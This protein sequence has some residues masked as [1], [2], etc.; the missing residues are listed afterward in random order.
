MTVS[1]KVRMPAFLATPHSHMRREFIYPHRSVRS[2]R[3]TVAKL[4]SAV[5]TAA[6]LC[7]SIA[8]Y[9]AE[10][11]TWHDRLCVT[12]LEWTG[13]PV[14]GEQTIELFEGLSTAVV[15]AVPVAR[16]ESNPLRFVL[17]AVAGLLALWAIQHRIALSRG[18]VLFLAALLLITACVVAIH[19]SSQFGAVEFGQIWL[20]GEVLVWLLLPVFSAAMFT[21]VQPIWLIGVTLT[22]LVQVFGIFWSAVRMAFCLAVMHYS[23]IL[24]VPILWFAL[25][26][27]ADMI[28]LMVFYSMAVHWNAS[29]YWRR[30]AL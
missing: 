19:P 16:F 6:V 26:V 12:L 30:K 10:F 28:Y 20:R 4:L 9:N 8:A 1:L 29:R 15:P 21:L 3:V 17:L 11:F 5:F 22:V 25:G 2:F 18:F 24:F 14:T 7:G 23:G 13:V 27:L